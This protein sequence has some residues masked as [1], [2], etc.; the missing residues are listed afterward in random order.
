MSTTNGQPTDLAEL[1]TQFRI[2]AA[3]DLLVLARIHGRELDEAAILSLNADCAGDFLGLQ[4][5]GEVAATG[6]ALIRQGLAQ[7]VADLNPATIDRLA[8]DYADIY[9]TQGLRTSPCESVWLDEDHPTQQGTRC[10]VRDWYRAQG[11]RVDDWRK[12]SD[13]HLVNELDFLAHL[14]AGAHQSIPLNAAARFMDE[15]PLRWIEEFAER[16]ADRCSTRF[17]AGLAL[18]TA[19]YLDELR[20]LLARL[21]DQPRPAPGS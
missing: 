13:D 11:L 12:R 18:L 9:L 17:Y 2:E 19:A 3:E 15:H 14:L 16:V 21:L 1:V 20:D 10:E 5:T 8:A 4:L 6:L 7:L